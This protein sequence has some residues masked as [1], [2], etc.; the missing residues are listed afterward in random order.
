MTEEQQAQWLAQ[1]LEDP[2]SPPPE[3]LDPEVIEALGVLRPDWVPNARVTVQDILNTVTREP[4]V[5]D[6]EKVQKRALRIQNLDLE[7]KE[8]IKNIKTK[9]VKENIK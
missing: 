4:N 6:L 7:Q 9:E 3:G 2:T 8:G 5:V 1:W